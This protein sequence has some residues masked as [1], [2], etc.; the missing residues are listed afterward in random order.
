MKI[1]E[2]SKANNF[3][4]ECKICYKTGKMRHEAPRQNYE[5]FFEKIRKNGKKC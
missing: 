3:I 2:N 1:L 5:F 4:T